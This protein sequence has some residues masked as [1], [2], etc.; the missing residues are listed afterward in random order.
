MNSA[1]AALNSRNQWHHAAMSFGSDGM[2][3]YLDGEIMA[4]KASY[5]GGLGSSSGGVGNKEPLVIGGNTVTKRRL[6]SLPN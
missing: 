1:S 2:V 4:S 6:H 5:K 3:L